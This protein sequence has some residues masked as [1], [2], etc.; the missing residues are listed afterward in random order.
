MTPRET[1]FLKTLID[2]GGLSFKAAADL[3]A[4]RQEAA[5]AGLEC[6]VWDL[7]VEKKLI[8]AEESAR[9]LSQVDGG[10]PVPAPAKPSGQQELGGFELL[11]RL[12]QGGMGAVY[13]ARQKSMDRLVALKILPKNLAKNQDF[14]SRFLREARAAGKLSHPNIVTGIDAGFADGYY[15]FAMEYVEGRNLGDRVRSDGPLPEK[16]VL[17]IGRQIAEA[18]EY[19]HDA[20]MV[21][22]DVKPENILV[23]REGQ[24]KLCDLGLA[25]TSGGSDD[26]ARVTQAGFAV[27]TPYYISPEQVRGEDPDSRADIYSLGC[28]LYHLLAGQPPF[29]GPSALATMQKHLTET[30][31][32]LSDLR[33]GTS[34]ALEAVI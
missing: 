34:R 12:G 29:V 20:G 32:R 6:L 17:E 9:I 21:H 15:Y 31:A 33:P 1:R 30:A 25:R 3:E 24:A 10:D 2:G 28:T 13:K 14:I 8:T 23:T 11:S 16:E 4:E 5:Q 18:L 22:R 26:E 7:A 19:A 27:G